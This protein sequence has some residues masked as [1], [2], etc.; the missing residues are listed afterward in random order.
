VG[1]QSPVSAG[2]GVE[3]EWD[4]VGGEAVAAERNQRSERERPDELMHRAGVGFS[5]LWR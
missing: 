2:A 4:V 1:Q 5:E 3:D